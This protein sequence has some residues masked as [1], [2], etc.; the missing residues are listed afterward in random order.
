[1]KPEPRPF[2]SLTFRFDDWDLAGRAYEK[3]RDLVFALD[4]DA[5]AYRIL[6]NESAYVVTVGIGLPPASL[7]QGL[8]NACHEGE[9]ASLP[10]EVSITLALR[11]EQFAA[12]PGT[13]FERRG[14]QLMATVERRPQ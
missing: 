9:D 13:R 10:D 4:I 1:M 2:W 7:V 12:T 3:S 14:E 6:L 11:H 8:Q 5:S